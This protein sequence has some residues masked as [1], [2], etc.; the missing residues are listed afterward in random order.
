[1]PG[2]TAA[3]LHKPRADRTVALDPSLRAPDSSTRVTART[4]SS[5][6]A[7]FLRF[8][9]LLRGHRPGLRG[10]LNYL[11]FRTP[12]TNNPSDTQRN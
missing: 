2:S 12:S 6:P 10:E 4:L 11:S 8:C 1:M 7:Q 5:E 9:A 3:A